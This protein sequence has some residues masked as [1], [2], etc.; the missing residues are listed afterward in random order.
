MFEVLQPT[1]E[2]FAARSFICSD[3]TAAAFR[4]DVK[5]GCFERKATYQRKAATYKRK[6]TTEEKLEPKKYTKYQI[7]KNKNTI[8]QMTLLSEK[9]GKK[10]ALKERHLQTKNRKL[11]KKS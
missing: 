1:K 4:E 9:T 11:P 6:A 10:E 3:A 8:V 5:E 2:S 7:K